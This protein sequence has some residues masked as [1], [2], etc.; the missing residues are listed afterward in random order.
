LL[1]GGWVARADEVPQ[2]PQIEIYAMDADGK[3]V[4]KVAAVPNFPI[5]NS[6]ELSPD[7]K[8][9]AVDGWRAGQDLTDAHLLIVNVKTGRVHDLGIGAMPTWSADGQWIAFSKYQPNGG[10]FLR[11]VDGD[12]EQLID[13]NGWAI[14]WSPDGFKTAYVRGGNIVVHDINADT[15]REIFPANQLVYQSI[16][17]NCKWSPDSTRICFKGRRRDGKEE[18]GIVSAIGNDPKLRVR[19]AGQDYDPDIGWHPDGKRV[20][21]PRRAMPGEPAQIYEFDPDDEKPPF[22]VPGQPK[23]RH[24]GGMGWSKDGKTLVFVSWK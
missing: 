14:Q 18:I 10:V 11:G 24:N 15:R 19:C 5:I 9:V 2:G 3:N 6:P 17:H 22:P 21:V 1:V 12:A 16:Y 7:G 23:D 8:F 20:T 13:R 4:K